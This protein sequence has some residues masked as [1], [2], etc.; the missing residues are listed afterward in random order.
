MR[1]RWDGSIQSH[2]APIPWKV[3]VGYSNNTMYRCMITK[4]IYADDPANV[5]MNA[6]NPEVVYEAIILGGNEQ[7]QLITNIRLGGFMA[8]DHNYWEFTLRPTS[9]DIS[10][11]ALEHHDGDCVM[12]QFIQGHDNYPQ[13]ICMSNGIHASYG[14]KKAD[15]PHSVR[16]YNGLNEKIDNKGNLTVTR[17]GGKLTDGVFKENNIADVSYSLTESL[18]TVTTSQGVVFKVDGKNGNVST[19]NG[20]TK[21][22]MDGKSNNIKIVAGST[23]IDIDGGSGKITLKGE[24]VDLGSS[25][26]DFVTMFTAL[27]SAFNS[28]THLVPQAPAGTLPSMPP[29][30]PLLSTVGSQTVKVQS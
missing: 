5:T 14:T 15:G 4:I 16:E 12:V 21:V 6:Q 7:G 3:G 24:M 8:G 9:K 13:I 26:S 25:V 23:E 19:V 17:K 28:H 20:T 22:T 30:A 18:F 10:K 1:K 27:A 11:D 29:M 2:N